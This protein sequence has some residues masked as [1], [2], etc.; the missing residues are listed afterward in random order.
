VTTVELRPDAP[1]GVDLYFWEAL[2]RLYGQFLAYALYRWEI[3]V[4]E[5]AI[6]GIPGVRTLGF[7]VDA[8][9][10]ELRLDVA[11]VLIVATGTLSMGIDALSR[12]LRR[13]LRLDGLPVRLAA[14][15]VAGR[16][17]PAPR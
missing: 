8:A 5:S 9:I 10:S 13:R 3:I 1:H 4:R 12:G 11:V 6:L 7:H 16:G 17:C 15:A 2:P 14:A